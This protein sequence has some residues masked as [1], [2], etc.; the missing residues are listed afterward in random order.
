MSGENSRTLT[1]KSCSQSLWGSRAG[2][3]MAVPCGYQ[4]PA[5]GFLHRENKATSPALHALLVYSSPA[6]PPTPSFT[7]SCLNMPWK[8]PWSHKRLRK[9][10][11]TRGL[12][13]TAPAVRRHPRP[14]HL[15]SYHRI[16]LQSR[17][18][19]SANRIPSQ[20][21]ENAADAVRSRDP[22]SDPRQQYVYSQSPSVRELTE[23]ERAVMLSECPRKRL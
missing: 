22:L 19:C 2:R 9:R 23:T 17:L 5:D 10:Q 12:T 13:E 14:Q 18:R 15:S 7:F 20:Y 6:P 3:G 4:C 11:I 16:R 21:V 8:K 1:S